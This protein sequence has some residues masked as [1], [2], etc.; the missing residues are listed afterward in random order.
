MKNNIKI[1]GEGFINSGEYEKVV[2][3]GSANSLGK[4]CANKV[5][6]N[7][8]GY[9]KGDSNFNYFKVNGESSINGCLSSENVKIHGELKVDDNSSIDELIVHGNARFNCDLKCN[10]VTIIGDLKVKGKLCAKE[11]D[12]HGNIYVD[13]D[14]ECDNIIVK[15]AIECGGLLNAEKID[16]YLRGNSYCKDIG[17]T[18]VNILK[19]NPKSFIKMPHIL[20]KKFECDT[21]EGDFIN[22]ENS[23]VVNIRGKDISLLTNCNIE[24]VEYHNELIISKNSTV[25]NNIK[26]G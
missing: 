14:I 18:S 19:Y 6:V 15:G 21:I 12:I 22:L 11:M 25:K 7:G 16:I 13:G 8:S 17:T 4:L 3:N 2:I 10:N 24:N 1:A 23:E 26:V 5:K 9:F 20:G